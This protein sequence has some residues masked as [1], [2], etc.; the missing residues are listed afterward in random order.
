MSFE[1]QLLRAVSH[2]EGVT[3]GSL[4]T[5]AFTGATVT[6]NDPVWE[7]LINGNTD[8]SVAPTGLVQLATLALE[9]QPGATGIVT[10]IQAKLV[11]LVT[12]STCD[13]T[14]DNSSDDLDKEVGGSGY[15]LLP[16]GRRGR[17]L[18]VSE[19][20]PR[21][22]T[23]RVGR[24]LAQP[25]GSCCGSW[26]GVDAF[27]G[28]INGD[29][30][31]DIKDV[32]RAS[33]LLLSQSSTAVI[34]TEYQ[35]MPLCPW[36]QQQLDP[37]LDGAFMPDDAV[38]LLLALSRKRRFVG[39]VTLALPTPPPQILD[40]QAKLF[41]ERT[42]AANDRVAVRLELQYAPAFGRPSD[43]PSLDYE[44][45]AAEEPALSSENNLLA[46][47]K[48][49][50]WRG[51]GTGLYALRTRGPD[52]WNSHNAWSLG[53]EWRVAM[54]VETT[55]SLGN[56]ETS[57]S[58]PFFGSSATLYAAQGFRFKPFRVAVVPPG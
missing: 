40:F 47:A 38:Y 12:C 4:A 46:S 44:L 51:H 55:D 33:L 48:Q 3:A 8:A 50:E 6:L 7:V 29:C 53:A 39:S 18:R 9:V 16:G 11:G 23:I 32:R 35:G 26:V 57:R 56:S 52:V 58:F 49:L 31:F 42:N 28:D 15:V 20:P 19:L 5:A 22:A 45:G 13:D 34:P 2:S 17:G 14:D 30:V 25:N 1:S 41:D 24:A 21:T 54:M 37:T 43:P 27:Y 10:F 36:Q